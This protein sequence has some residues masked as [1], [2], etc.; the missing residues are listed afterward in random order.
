MVE[1]FASHV[2]VIVGDIG[3]VGSLVDDGISGVKFQYNSAKALIQAVTRFEQLNREELGENAYRKYKL[4]YAQDRN[5]EAMRM[6]Y[7]CISTGVKGESA[8]H[9]EK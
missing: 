4:E 5:Y 7:D 3:N 1:A 2:P 9:T 6:I 8:V